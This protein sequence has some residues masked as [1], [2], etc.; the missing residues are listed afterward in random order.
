MLAAVAHDLRTPITSLRLRAEFID[1][2][3]TRFAPS[4]A[5]TLACRPFALRRAVGNLVDNAARYGRGGVARVEAGPE[6]ARIVVE[7]AGPGIPEAEL[8][9]VFDPFVRLEASRSR[10]T[11]GAGLGLAIARSILRGHGGDVRLENRPEGG[12][13]ATAILPRSA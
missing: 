6:E 10:E 9:R 1:D 5:V 3:D 11:G 4:P 2:E 13:R 12:L 8:E 7:D